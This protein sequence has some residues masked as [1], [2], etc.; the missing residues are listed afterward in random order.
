MADLI[1]ERI[2]ESNCINLQY[3]MHR[4]PLCLEILEDMLREELHYINESISACHPLL[5]LD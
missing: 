1:T 5:C 3:R 2:E 4:I